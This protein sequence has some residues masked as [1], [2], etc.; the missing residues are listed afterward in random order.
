MAD[1]TEYKESRKKGISGQIP[2]ER[3]DLIILQALRRIM[4][5]VDLHSKKLSMKYSITT[6]QLICLLTIVENKSISVASLAKK[7]HLSPSTV[8]GILDRLTDKKLVSRKRDKEDRRIVRVKPTTKGREY[9]KSAPSPLQDKLMQVLSEL[10]GLEQAA[11]SMSLTRIVELME[12]E[13]IEASPF[14][15]D[16]HIA[17]ANDLP[18]D[19]AKP[20]TQGR[21]DKR[22]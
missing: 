16:G 1:T 21:E 20:D 3:Y 4:R 9:A 12:A 17:P 18:T 22:Y 7:I 13:D 15:E 19:S 8:V 5:A 14:L 11:I 10:S 6:P 2:A